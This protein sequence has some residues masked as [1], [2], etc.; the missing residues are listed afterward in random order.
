M[1]PT[2]FGDMIGADDLLA[3]KRKEKVD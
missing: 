3:F 1:K 2:G